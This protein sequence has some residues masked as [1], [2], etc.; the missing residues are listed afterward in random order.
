MPTKISG[1]EVPRAI[2]VN[3]IVS[4]LTPKFF[5]SDDEFETNLSALTTNTVSEI[6]K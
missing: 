4:S 2:I 6:R 3:P 5:A 1:A